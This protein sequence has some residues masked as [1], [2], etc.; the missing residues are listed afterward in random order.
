M[1]FKYH[2]GQNVIP[3]LVADLASQVIDVGTGSGRWVIEV[4]EFPGA[5]LL[6]M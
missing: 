3:S 2:L 6:I 1:V 5:P 4:A